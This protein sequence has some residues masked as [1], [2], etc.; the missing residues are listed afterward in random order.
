MFA[1][2]LSLCSFLFTYHSK[3]SALFFILL[4][5]KENAFRLCPRKD[6]ITFASFQALFFKAHHCCKC[7]RLALTKKQSGKVDKSFPAVS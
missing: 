6:M 4:N 3:R 5:F 7:V 1:M 2:L